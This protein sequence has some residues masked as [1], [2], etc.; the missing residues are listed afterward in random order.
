[1][2]RRIL[3]KHKLWL[4]YGL[5]LALFVAAVTSS[6]ITLRDTQTAVRDIVERAQPAAFE[7]VELVG[8]IEYAGSQLGY[9]LMTRSPEHL[10]TYTQAL[11]A[12]GEAAEALAA[13]P[14]VMSDPALAARVEAARAQVDAFAAYREQ[15]VELVGDQAK[16]YP[17]FELATGELNPHALRQQQLISEMI[18]SEAQEPL[19][20]QRRQL[21]AELHELRYVWVS[22]L[23]SVRS[24]LAFRDETSRQNVLSFRDGAAD[25]LARV[26]QYATLYTFEQEIAMEELADGFPV[27]FAGVDRLFE[28]HGGEKWR[29]DAYL[30]EAEVVPLMQGLQAELH[31]IA[32]DLRAAMSARGEGV[33]E[34]VGATVSLIGPLLLVGVLVGVL[35]AW[36][37]TRSVVGPLRAAAT[38]LHDIAE[39]EGD[40]TRRLEVHGRDEVTYLATGFNAFV[41][42]IEALVR[43]V[44]RSVEQLGEAARK[45]SS[46]TSETGEG[47]ACQQAETAH[48]ATAMGQMT[49]TAQEVAQSAGEAARAARDAEQETQ[50]GREVVGATIESIRSLATE[51]EQS[52]RVIEKLEAD[53]AAIGTVLDVIRSIAEQTNLLALNAAIEAARAGEQGRGFAVVAD[54]VRSLAARTQESTAEVQ[55]LIE[56]LQ[57]GARDAVQVMEQSRERAH[58]S[59]DQV[60]GAGSSLTS[61]ERAVSTINDMND[62][63]ASAAEQQS[64][65]C[66]EVNRNVVA[67]SEV[68]ERSAEGAG[69]LTASATQLAELAAQLEGLVDQFK[70]GPG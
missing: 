21:A 3:I 11:T 12:V 26:Q 27:Y 19:S 18:L 14:R 52:A 36:L 13:Q 25:A 60:A 42:K 53:S 54:E 59:V 6:L 35:G 31:A 55:G 67:I 50:H 61:I 64:Q 33:V 51:I 23:S 65:V 70:V 49:A 62:R 37:V 17:G 57:G 9:Y 46:V 34:N 20:A 47:V 1:M 28:I 63:I 15:F 5:V 43:R 69:E 22:L 29:S 24:Y 2:Q 32:D 7:A 66:V 30:I 8:R 45:M 68:S 40:L 39:G 38:A 44:T 56:Q 16:N 10:A 41:D 58:A 4:G 48:A